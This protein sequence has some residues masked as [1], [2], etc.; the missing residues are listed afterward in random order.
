MNAKIRRKLRRAK[1]RVVARELG[2]MLAEVLAAE[3]ALELLEESRAE[4]TRRIV[5]SMADK[6]PV[7][8]FPPELPPM[9]K[10]LAI[11][12]KVEL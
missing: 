4:K 7:M 3:R 8:Q 2:L 11:N 5:R 9:P 6:L 12:L 10:F 1:A